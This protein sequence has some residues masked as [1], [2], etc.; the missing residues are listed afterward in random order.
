[1]S[2]YKWFLQ[3]H[4]DC[5]R[6]GISNRLRLETLHVWRKV[7]QSGVQPSVAAICSWATQCPERFDDLRATEIKP[8]LEGFSN[9][10]MAA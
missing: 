7:W 3:L 9:H 2:F 4:A 8:E 6:R 10:R 5:A 1:M